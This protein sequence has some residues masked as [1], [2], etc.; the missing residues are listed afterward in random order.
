[1]KNSCKCKTRSNKSFLHNTKLRIGYELISIKNNTITLDKS[2]FTLHFFGVICYRASWLLV[3]NELI[4]FG[5]PA[6]DLLVYF[7]PW[8]PENGCK[9]NYWLPW[10]TVLHKAYELNYFVKCSIEFFAKSMSNNSLKNNNT[11][12]NEKLYYTFFSLL[13]LKYISNLILI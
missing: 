2:Y 5:W 3:R 9:E 12:C 11:N 13:K 1:M 8:L 6:S 7:F 10:F 4:N